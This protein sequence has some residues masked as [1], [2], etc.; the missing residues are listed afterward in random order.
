[1][2]S[3]ALYQASQGLETSNL[4]GQPTT[5]H[6]L[7]LRRSQLVR[8]DG[9]R[10]RKPNRLV[11]GAFVTAVLFFVAVLGAKQWAA[12]ADDLAHGSAHSAATT[13]TVKVD[14]PSRVTSS[15]VV[16]P[17]TVRP[18]QTAM[19]YA[20]VSG[21]LT[22]WH[23]DLGATVEANEVLAEIETPELDQEVAQ[24]EAQAIE[25]NAATVQSQAEQREAEADLK[26]AEAQLVRAQAES[27]LA[28]S[29]L[30]RREKLLVSRAISQDEFDTYQKQAEA[31]VADLNAANSDLSRRRTNLATRQAI[32]ESRQATA[33]AR[34]SNVD[35][36]KE[37]QAFKHIVAPFAGTITRRAAE[38]GMLVTASKDALFV[39][40][41]MSRVRVQSNVP[42]A[43]SAQAK[44]G[45]VSLV[46][47]PEQ[48]AQ[49]V[50][51]SIT[52]VSNSVDST[53]RTMLAEIELENGAGR[54]QP[55]S[56]AQVSL[57]V[58]GDDATWTVPTNTV[59]MRVEG[60][61]IVVVNDQNQVEVRR[62]NLGRDMGTRVVVEG[63]RGDERLII[64]PTDDLVDGLHVQVSQHDVASSVAQR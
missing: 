20:R 48:S 4:Q 21:Y 12:M 16:L 47:V 39:V 33:N 10:K 54:F 11:A 25:A 34:R 61:H 40:E 28:A 32:I 38:T 18:W 52:R 43:Y 50:S 53:N 44:V 59:Q 9:Q 19:V 8:V 15:N 29:L 63:V 26:V 62:V 41:D 27:E 45:V 35:R 30:A 46:R 1:M 64:N 56:Y 36:L 3:A 17:A 58:Q 23:K 13:K 42:Q 55:G 60:P 24:A 49:A 6:S 51:A 2:S 7:E 14:R 5:G 22:V 31:R 57:N 37:M